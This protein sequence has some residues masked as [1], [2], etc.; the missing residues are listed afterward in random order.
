LIRIVGVRD[1]FLLTAS[2]Q[3]LKRLAKVLQ[4]SN[5]CAVPARKSLK[6]A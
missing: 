5:H 3:N 6:G 2:I 1:E 4:P